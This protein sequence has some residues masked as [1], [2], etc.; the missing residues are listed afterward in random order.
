LCMQ[1]CG[2]QGDYD[3]CLFHRVILLFTQVLSTCSQ[4]QGSPV[5]SSILVAAFS[6]AA[7]SFIFSTARLA[8]AI[9][10]LVI[11]IG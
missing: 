10:F 4:E 11:L 8:A 9:S 7:L 5:V 2:E 3:Q 1:P 6:A